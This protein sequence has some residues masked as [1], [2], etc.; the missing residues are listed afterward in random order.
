ME[1]AGG[2]LCLLGKAKKELEFFGNLLYDVSDMYYLI[3]IN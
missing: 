1:P 3:A 2:I